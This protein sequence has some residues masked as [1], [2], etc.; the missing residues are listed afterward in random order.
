MHSQSPPPLSKCVCIQRSTV[1]LQSCTAYFARRSPVFLLRGHSNSGKAQLYGNI[2][3]FEFKEYV[4]R[5]RSPTGTQPNNLAPCMTGKKTAGEKKY[6]NPVLH[7]PICISLL[8]SH[9]HPNSLNQSK[10]NN[11]YS[12]Q[13]EV[14]PLRPRPLPSCLLLG[15]RHNRWF[16]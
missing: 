1:L 7:H 9:P 16:L 15:L 4:P 11:L 5:V 3:L 12:I 2:L 13:N 10:A 6:I 14:L 8:L